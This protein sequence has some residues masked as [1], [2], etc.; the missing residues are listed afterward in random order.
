MPDDRF[1]TWV[2]AADAAMIAVTAGGVGGE[3]DACL[4][5]F[6]S[7]ASIEPPRYVVWLSR[8]NHT[9]S[10]AASATML[11]VHLLGDG[12]LELAELLGSVTMD[13][14]RRKLAGL[15]RRDEDG[16][17]IL[18]AC[19]AWFAGRVIERFDGGDHQGFLLEPTA[20]AC[21]EPFRPLR[22]HDTSGI[23]P[24]HPAG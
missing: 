11:G 2:A 10:L 4:V 1:A 17:T 22:L 13:D 7:Q 19:S 6:H 8:A 15:E 23:E 16:A 9:T 12:Q 3:V 5:G 21:P 14:D 18:S 20:S 24:G